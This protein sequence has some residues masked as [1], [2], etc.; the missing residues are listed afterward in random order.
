M[1]VEF[2]AT[3][4]SPCHELAP[5]IQ[6]FAK[7]NAGRLTLLSVSLDR[8]RSAF[9]RHIRDA[10]PEHPVLWAGPEAAKPWSVTL[11][12]SVV[13]VKDGRVLARWRGIEEIRT[14]MQ[15]ITHS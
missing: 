7:R 13:L 12:P 11:M 15:S 8:S 10:K 2:W 14:G 9:D 4:C 6:G 1:L 5:E 3:W